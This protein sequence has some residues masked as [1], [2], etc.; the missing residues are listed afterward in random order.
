MRNHRKFNIASGLSQGKGLPNDISV[1]AS[2]DTAG[3][4]RWVIKHSDGGYVAEIRDNSLTVIDDLS[5]ALLFPSR[6]AAEGCLRHN[7]GLLCRLLL[8][9]DERLESREVANPAVP[10]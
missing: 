6:E 1:D 4:R 7:A 5:R 3:L 8:T 9:F 2:S 10:R